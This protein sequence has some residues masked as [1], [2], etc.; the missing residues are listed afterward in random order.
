MAAFAARK[1]G[2]MS[3][4]YCVHCGHSQV[5]PD[6]YGG[7]EIN[8]GACRKVFVAPTKTVSIGAPFGTTANPPSPRR[9]FTAWQRFLRGGLIA[10]FDK[11]ARLPS[12]ADMQIRSG[13]GGLLKL[14]AIAV[15]VFT[16]LVAFIVYT[17]AM[18]EWN[19]VGLLVIVIVVGVIAYVYSKQIA[20]PSCGGRRP[21][22][23]GRIE[24]DR[25]TGST[26]ITHKDQNTDL[27]GRIT[28]F[29]YR[30]QTVPV[31]VI[32]Y[33]TSMKC[34]KCGHEW[35]VEEKQVHEG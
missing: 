17:P 8:C 21:A 23:T 13:L 14:M 1:W 27:S 31:T 10:V 12:D 4:V 33:A 35:T 30:D 26:T 25:R 32:L 18:S 19:Y 22:V 16:A 20:C 28:G 6:I 34:S 2:N 29:S 11:S 24:L 15:L 7:R 3:T 9:E 5:V